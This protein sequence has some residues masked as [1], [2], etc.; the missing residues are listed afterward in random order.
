MATKEAMLFSFLGA[1][2]FFFVAIF[3]GLFSFC[4]DLEKNMCGGLMRM[5][6]EYAC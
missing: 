5:H 3:K 2:F 1:F 6:Y 4:K